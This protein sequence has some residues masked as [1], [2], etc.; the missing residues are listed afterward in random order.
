M[1]IKL[2]GTHRV[3]THAIFLYANPH[4]NPNLDLWPLNPQTM[5]LLRYLKVIPYTKFETLES[6]SYAADKQINRQIN[7]RTRSVGVHG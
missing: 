6:F 7:R 5:S 3:R 4:P 1:Q 2:V